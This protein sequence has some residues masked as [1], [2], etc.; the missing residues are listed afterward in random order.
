MKVTSI[1]LNRMSG[2]VVRAS[3]VVARA[4][5]A[6][7]RAS[8]APTSGSAMATRASAVPTSGSAVAT[9]PSSVTGRVPMMLMVLAL[10]LASVGSVAGTDRSDQS[11]PSA[12]VDPREAAHGWR[13]HRGPYFVSTWGVDI[14]GVRLIASGWMLQF[15]YR[16][17]DARKARPLLSSH[18]KPYL[19]DRASGA[20]L[21]VPAMENIGELRQTTPPEDG[22]VYYMIFGNANRIV[23]RG[24]RV[25]V[26]VGPFVADDLTVE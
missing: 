13:A 8:A 12:G 24:N 15:K 1:Q 2:G 10:S 9:R 20:T 21:A 19:V 17:V 3:A 25:N 7:S 14:I 4:F 16:V 6:A 18:A 26:A 23:Q 22:R 11:G 5:A